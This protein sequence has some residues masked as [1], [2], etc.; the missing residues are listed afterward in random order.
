MRSRSRSACREQFWCAASN[1]FSETLSERLTLCTYR[2]PS[3]TCSTA[4]SPGPPK[5]PN[6][7]ASSRAKK[8]TR[9]TN[10]N[11]RKKRKQR[12]NNLKIVPINKAESS[13]YPTRT[14]KTSVPNSSG[15]K[16]PTSPKTDST[17]PSKNHPSNYSA[18]T[19]CSA[20]PTKN[21]PL[22][23]IYASQSASSSKRKTTT[24]KSQIQKKHFPSTPETYSHSH[25]K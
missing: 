23:E 21:T 22:S 11:A 15:K 17:T 9:R 1:A 8:S 24:S 12:R 19:D 20:S 2:Q 18:A 14:T 7:S 25:Q 16:C 6:W 10:P 3:P 4:F 5:L 13:K